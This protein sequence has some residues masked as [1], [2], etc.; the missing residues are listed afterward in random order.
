MHSHISLLVCSLLLSTAVAE[1]NTSPWP[2]ALST[3]LATRLGNEYVRK[4]QSDPYCPDAW[5]LDYLK[6]KDKPFS[7]PWEVYKPDEPEDG[8]VCEYAISP[9]N[10]AM[11]IMDVHGSDE[12]EIDSCYRDGLLG[13][14]KHKLGAKNVKTIIASDLVNDSLRK[15]VEAGIKAAGKSP[16]VDSAVTIRPGDKAWSSF[17]DNAVVTGILNTICSSKEE[18]G[19]PKVK[20]FVAVS[21]KAK[22]GKPDLHIVANFS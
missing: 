15:A 13:N 3:T 2:R 17:F 11:V 18:M 20:N 19:N 14:L 12:E 6:V 16:D 1:G 7:A 22:P 4:Q 8:L 9:E 5:M 21:R 10:K